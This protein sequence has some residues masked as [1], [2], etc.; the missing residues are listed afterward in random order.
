MN[1]L[2][3]ASTWR[4]GDRIFVASTDY[5]FDQA[6]EF[7][8]KSVNGN[9]VTIKGQVMFEHFGEVYEEVDMR[10]EVGLLT[11]DIQIYGKVR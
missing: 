11:R 9:Q 2:D 1:L 7:E 3:D 4:A 8:I 10:A 6:E 5:D